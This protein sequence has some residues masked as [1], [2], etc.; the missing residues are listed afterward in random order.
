MPLP[1]Q[2]MA[3]VHSDTRIATGRLSAEEAFCER[4]ESTDG[5]PGVSH[6]K[7]ARVWDRTPLRCA[8]VSRIV[9]SSFAIN[10]SNV[11]VFAQRAKP[12]P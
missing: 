3:A 8:R 9:A 7:F 12:V 11:I 10:G 1:N 5:V 6:L 4:H 2:R